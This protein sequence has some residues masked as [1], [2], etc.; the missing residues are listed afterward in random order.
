MR[1]NIRNPLS[2]TLVLD[3]LVSIARAAGGRV[4]GRET[5]DGAKKVW[6]SRL[7]P[8]KFARALRAHE[9]VVRGDGSEFSGAIDGRPFS[10]EKADEG[11]LFIAVV[12]NGYAG[13]LYNVGVDC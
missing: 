11:D 10:F 13:R 9:I 5:T 8:T 12:R 6:L 7:S 1:K 4:V 2:A 3:Q